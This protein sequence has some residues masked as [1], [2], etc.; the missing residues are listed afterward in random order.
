M[1]AL[2]SGICPKYLG[3]D[4]T[5]RNAGILANEFQANDGISTQKVFHLDVPGKCLLTV[6][7]PLAVRA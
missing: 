6:V 1:V 5:Q 7:L 2:S 4:I 3:G